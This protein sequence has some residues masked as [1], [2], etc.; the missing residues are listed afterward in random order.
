MFGL[1]FARG[2]IPIQSNVKRTNEGI[3]PKYNW[4]TSNGLEHIVLRTQTH[5]QK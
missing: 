4:H 3:Q 2:S 5:P 1:E